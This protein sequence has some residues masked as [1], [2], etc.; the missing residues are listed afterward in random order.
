M[1]TIEDA[2]GPYIVWINN[3][4]EGWQ[5]TSYL[6]IKEALEGHRYSP[7]YVITKKCEYRVIEDV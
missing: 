7:E 5:P 6:T 3:G 4:C 2:K 1:S